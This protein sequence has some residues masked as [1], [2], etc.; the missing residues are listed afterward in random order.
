M[1]T[2]LD[3]NAALRY[4]LEDDPDRAEEVARVIEDGAEVS[5]EVLAECVYV[6]DGVYNVPHSLIAESLGILL[7]EVFCLRKDVAGTVLGVFSGSRFD[8]VNCVLAAERMVGN[9]E[10]LTFDKKMKTLLQRVE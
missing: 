9:C 2:L 7:D 10:V 8:F 3:A 6:L 5:V 1:E 4:L